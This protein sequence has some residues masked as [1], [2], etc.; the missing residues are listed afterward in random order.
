MTTYLL[1][2]MPFI[3]TSLYSMLNS[4]VPQLVIRLIVM[5]VEDKYPKH[6]SEKILEEV[7]VWMDRSRFIQTM[8]PTLVQI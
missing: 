2:T 4:I 6:E 5:A 3:P 8:G 1:S 7:G